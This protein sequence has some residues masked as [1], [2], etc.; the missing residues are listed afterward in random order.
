M[1]WNTGL[2]SSN[3]FAYLVLNRIGWST[4][5]IMMALPAFIPVVLLGFLPESPKFLNGKQKTE[6]CLTSLRFVLNALNSTPTRAHQLV[7]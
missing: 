2:L 1:F 7:D 6:E 4:Y 5:T 3:G